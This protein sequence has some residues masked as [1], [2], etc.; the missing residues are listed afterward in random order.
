MY[1]YKYS[2]IHMYLVWLFNCSL[3][4]LVCACVCWLKWLRV[5]F[6][7]FCSLLC[8]DDI[9]SRNRYSFYNYTVYY[10]LTIAIIID[11]FFVYKWFIEIVYKR[12]VHYLHQLQNNLILPS[13]LLS[14]YIQLGNHLVKTNAKNE[15]CES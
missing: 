6:R 8:V 12:C 14:N 15:G 1:I 4:C 13:Y 9:F 5:H 10:R 2:N 3:F 7:R 11:F